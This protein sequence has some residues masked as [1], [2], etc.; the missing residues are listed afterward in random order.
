MTTGLKNAAELIDHVL[1]AVDFSVNEQ[2][3]QYAECQPFSA[4]IRAKKPVF[5]I[6]YLAGTGSTISAE[7]QD[8][9]CSHKGNASYTEGFSIVI[10]KLNLD[11]WARY[12]N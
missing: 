3:I 9:I 4:F 2:C 8:S 11:G 5:N 10:K 7:V 6:E 12:C 1:D